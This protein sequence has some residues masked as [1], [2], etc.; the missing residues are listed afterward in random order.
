MTTRPSA[1]PPETERSDE[2]AA[3]RD[4][5]MS[6][7]DPTLGKKRKAD[8]SRPIRGRAR[9]IASARSERFDFKADVD[10]RRGVRQRA[11]RHEVDAAGGQRRHPP[12]S[13]AAAN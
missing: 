9:S 6:L 1:R 2:A 8:A 5:A 13:D 3:L 7:V 11:D 12:N 4:S 10:G